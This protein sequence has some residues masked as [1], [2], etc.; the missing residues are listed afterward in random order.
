MEKSFQKYGKFWS[1]LL[2]LFSNHTISKC[3]EWST[4]VARASLYS[5]SQNMNMQ[6]IGRV[7]KLIQ[8]KLIPYFVE[9]VVVM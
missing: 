9:Y 2:E 6:N 3:K 4:A 5:S 1:L 8:F 7:V